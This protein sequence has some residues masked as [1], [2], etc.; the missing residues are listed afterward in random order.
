MFNLIVYNFF[1]WF[2]IL[3]VIG[4]G[5]Y[6]VLTNKEYIYRELAIQLLATIIIVSGA[7][8]LSF[9]FGSDIFQQEFWGGKIERFVHDEA[10]TREYDCSY[11]S[12]TTSS[13]GAQSCRTISKTC[14]ERVPD[15]YHI[16]NSNNLE[17]S[18]D[19]S[20]FNKAKSQFGS[21]KEN[22]SHY[23]QTYFSKASG[24]GERFISIPNMFIATAETHLYINYLTGSKFTIQ[25][26]DLQKDTIEKYKSLLVPYPELKRN[27]WATIHV[28]RVLENNSSI[29]ENLKKQYQKELEILAYKY[30]KAKQ[31]NPLIYIVKTNDRLFKD[32]LEAFYKKGQKNDSIFILGIDDNGTVQWSDSINWSKNKAYEVTFK[33]EFYDLNIK[34]VEKIVSKYDDNIKNNW[35]R[36]S[37]EEEFGYLKEEVEIDW[38]FQ[39]LIILFNSIANGLIFM[40][41][42]NKFSKYK[43]RKH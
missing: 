11:E 4:I 36:L 17:V 35:Q 5:I 7:T 3:V 22:V 16:L 30:G 33:N 6:L 32:A 1:F 15:S 10:Y 43:L 29:A 38:R 26:K 9:K 14:T 13:N 24:E 25:K 19:K 42:L 18:I 12:C 37:M 27:E 41:F 28:D 23:D 8:F 21:K 20:R 31:I 2:N 40:I 39:L 34:D